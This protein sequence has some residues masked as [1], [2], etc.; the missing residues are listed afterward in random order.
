MFSFSNAL[1]VHLRS[2]V[3]VWSPL[4]LWKRRTPNITSWRAIADGVVTCQEFRHV[5][6][7]WI[8]GVLRFRTR[9]QS[10]SV[11]L[12]SEHQMVYPFVFSLSLHRGIA[13][14]IGEQLCV[15]REQQNLS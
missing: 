14:I 6:T 5:S 10:R 1:D 13:M 8:H 9:L 12:P 4:Q 2:V 7:L 15:L 11:S 3:R